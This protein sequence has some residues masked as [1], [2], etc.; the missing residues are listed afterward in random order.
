MAET[1]EEPE[2]TE[3]KEE[4]TGVIFRQFF[5]RKSCTYTYLL[6]CKSTR[7]CVLIDPVLECVDRDLQFINEL[8]LKLKYCMNTHCLQY[9]YLNCFDTKTVKLRFSFLFLFFFLNCY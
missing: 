1:A 9:T 6:G 7:E 4:E 2:T 3:E 5:D 8:E